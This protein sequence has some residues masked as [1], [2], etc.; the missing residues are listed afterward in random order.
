[1]AS[2]CLH[3]AMLW[4]VPS[5][6]GTSGALANSTGVCGGA[7]SSPLRETKEEETGSLKQFLERNALCF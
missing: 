6:N 7:T 1:M 5:W 3:M 4:R 2:S